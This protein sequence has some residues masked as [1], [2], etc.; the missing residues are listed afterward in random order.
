MVCCEAEGSGAKVSRSWRKGVATLRTSE[1]LPEPSRTS[2]LA[3]NASAAA[4][5]RTDSRSRRVLLLPRR[6]LTAGPSVL[7]LGRLLA[8]GP[9]GLA[10]LAILADGTA[11]CAP[12]RTA[13]SAL[14]S[15]KATCRARFSRFGTHSSGAP[16]LIPL[17]SSPTD[18]ARGHAGPSAF[19]A[20]PPLAPLASPP[21][22][23][24]R[25]SPNPSAPPAP[26]RSD[27]LFRASS[28]TL[29][30]K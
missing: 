2:G 12:G 24:G 5:T 29:G 11:G 28:S 17:A 10:A 8:A 9:S 16:P 20:P 4:A 13:T 27:H 23:A 18:A 14:S 30:A 3:L 22:G 1:D 25:G 7:L 19:P 26:P 6:S 15:S 21:A